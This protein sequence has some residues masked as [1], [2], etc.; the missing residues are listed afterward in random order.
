MI[1]KIFFCSVIITH[2]FAISLHV[3]N[4]IT[5][6]YLFNQF[7]QKIQINSKINYIIISSSK[8][9]SLMINHFLKSKKNDFLAKH[10]ALFC[11]NL[12]Q[13]PSIFAKFFIL[14]KIKKLKY[15]ILLI[16]KNNKFIKKQNNI[17]VYKLNN[18]LIKKIYF[19][20][21]QKELRAL[22]KYRF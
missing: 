13:I 9:A 22:L 21:S 14:P 20:S 2:L 16:Y 15:S 12:S 18:L 4:V 1:K 8:H 5:P 10:H 7:D 11:I 3:G 17:I 19:L 6:F